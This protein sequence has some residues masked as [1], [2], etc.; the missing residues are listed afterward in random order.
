MNV[1]IIGPNLRDQ[2]KGQFHVHAAGCRDIARTLLANGQSERDTST[3]DFPTREAIV[4]EWYDFAYDEDPE[5]CYL[6]FWFAPCVASL[7]RTLI[8]EES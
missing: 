4:A 7:P 6:D 8:K 2:S 5:G 1:T 3:F